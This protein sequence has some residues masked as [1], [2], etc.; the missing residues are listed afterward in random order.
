MDAYC[1]DTHI[2]LDFS[3]SLIDKH[4]LT[5]IPILSPGDAHQCG[6]K[7]LT[8]LPYDAL[9]RLDSHV[10]LDLL[11]SVE[12]KQLTIEIKQLT[13]SLSVVQ[14]HNTG[15]IVITWDLVLLIYKS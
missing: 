15:L 5:N 7:V 11:I 9:H 13:I 6:G 2:F 12:I 10:Y 1:F 4:S 14:T 8:Q 3:L